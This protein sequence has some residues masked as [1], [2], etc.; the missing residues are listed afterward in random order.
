MGQLL[1]LL[2]KGRKA[3]AGIGATVVVLVQSANIFLGMS[4]KIS[5]SSSCATKRAATCTPVAVDGEGL[6]QITVFVDGDNSSAV[7]V[8]NSSGRS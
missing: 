1:Q 7:T 2:N 6:V 8:D 5:S 3:G 4:R